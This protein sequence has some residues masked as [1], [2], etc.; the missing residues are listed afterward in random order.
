MT[1][2]ASGQVDLARLPRA[3][4]FAALAAAGFNAALFGLGR[5]M[6][7]ELVLPLPSGP[8]PLGLAAV[9]AASFAAA[10]AGAAT[11]ALLALVAGQPFTV[12]RLAAFVALLVSLAGPLSLTSLDPRARVL[13]NA[14]HVSAAIVI[15]RV[16]TLV[17]RR[18]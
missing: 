4:L 12:F 5:L 11:L 8:E 7:L 10:G 2:P 3:A 16:L 18:D 9:V 17:P 13:L 1:A 15:V 14:M 6:G